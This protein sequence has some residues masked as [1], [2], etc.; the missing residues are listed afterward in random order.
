MA[1]AA[2]T[3]EPTPASATR[4]ASTQAA[5]QEATRKLTDLNEQRNAALLRDDNAAA[6]AFGVEA[7]NVKLSI[8][9]HADKIE[10]LK[11]LVAKD[12]QERRTK[13]RADLIERVGKMLDERMATVAKI[14]SAIGNLVRGWR[15][16]IEQ[17][18]RAY[19]AYPNGPPPTGFALTNGELI[20]LLG[21]ELF[22]Q[23]AT[24]PVTGRPQLERLPPTLP[25][26]KCPDYMMLNQPEKITP[27]HTAIEQ[28]NAHARNVM[29]SKAGVSSDAS[30]PAINGG[31]RSAAEETL[32][33]LLRQQAA[34]AEDPSTPDENYRRLIDQIAQAQAAVSAEQQGAH[35]G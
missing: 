26:P 19:S 34:I 20:Q 13:E 27:L 28:A 8:A 5:L 21:A 32:G 35:H 15:Q 4:L 25:G 11:A 16:L 10:L 14:E 9:A 12:E 24:T 1:A 22:R 29:E 33:K 17:S 31:P 6:I 18:D 3:S 7:A 23:G 30:E 2:R